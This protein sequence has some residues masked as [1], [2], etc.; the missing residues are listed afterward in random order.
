MMINHYFKVALRLIK[1]SFLF[2]SIHILGF[3]WGMAV[4]FL[5]YLW[6][7]DEFTFED[8]NPDAGRIFRVIEANCS[9]SGEV[10]ENPYTSKLLADAFRKEFPQ[11]EEATYLGNVDMTSLRSG[12]KFLSLNW[13]RVDTAFFDVFHFPVVE[14]DPGRLKSGFNHIVLSETLAKKF[15]GNEPAV[16][17]EVMY[18]R[19]MDGESVLRIVGVVKVPRKS[20]IQFDAIVGQSFFDK[21][22]VN[23]VRMSSPWDVRD[24]MVYV[25]MRP[26]TSVSD[27]DRVRMSRI[28]SKHTHMERLLRFQPLR[29]IHLK[30]DFAD[31]SVKNHGS[32]ASI[33]LFIILA[34]LIIFMGAFNFTT[35]STA[36]AALR[37]KEI[38]VRKVTGAKRK[39]LIVQFLSE[40]LVQAFISLILA[41]ALTELLLPVFNRIMDKD[42]TL[43]ASWS[44][45]VYV[46]LGIIGVGCLSGSYPAFYLS[47]VNPL[48]AFKG[49]QKN[50]KKGGLIRGLLCV[51][52]VIAITLLLCTGIV[53]KQLNYLQNKDLGLE[54]E[55]VVSI[56]T[57]LW[58][59]VDG[60]KQEI[61]KN[62]NV[63][64]VSMGAEIT[65]YLEGDKSQGDVLRWTDESGETDSLRM[66]C[67]W[68]DGDFVNTFGL[69]LLKGE[70]LKADGGA[71]FSGTYDFPVI[72]NEAA[73]KA[74]KVADPIGMEISGGFG[75]G[76]NKKRIVGVVQDFNFQS[77]RQKIK[78]AYLMYSPECLGNIHIKIA[79]EHKQE[80]LNFIQKKFEEMAPFFIKE[81]KYK[82]FSDALNR[83]YE[84]ERQQ[85]R[86]LLA[87]TI[88]AVVIA[89]MG[90]FG[91][92][93]LSTRQRTKEI[94][95][96]KVNGAHSGGIVKMF[97]LEYLKWVGIAFVPA[98]PLGYL[99]M[100]H[101][102]DEFAYR[103]TMS[104]WLFLGGGLIIAGITLLTVIGQTWRTASQNPVRSLRYE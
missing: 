61:L 12:D 42:I 43:Q 29:D 59:N 74:M 72:I 93:T 57:G 9:E 14:G 21:I 13:M 49:G 63:R 86:M 20:H 44:V 52:F 18:N 50:G 55:N 66:M 54:K 16:G 26:E 99:F 94:G 60:F 97:C 89:M 46:V 31:I 98:C 6:V 90:V 73:R 53:F 58:Y 84:Q 95:I 78:P 88:L 22:D 39:T 92:V 101:W 24:A 36:R 104:W 15:F 64:S 76:T 27:S 41:L 40:S 75:V 8:H 4:A 69:K 83:N 45:L 17:K 96:R 10:T 7:I 85:S 28:L 80:T 71:Y 81:F 100:Y 51:Q 82:F 1:R 25:K 102:L 35:L 77:L 47:A 33:Y 37:Y 2:S 56:Y 68:A 30:T 48:I 91:L 87:F 65:D 11:V 32:M 79:P 70:G 34:V 3:V 67:I 103:T 38:G 62:P 19:G 5:I 23:I